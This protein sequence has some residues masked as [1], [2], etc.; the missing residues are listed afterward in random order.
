MPSSIVRKAVVPVAGFGTS[1]LPETKTMPK[2]MLPIVDIP[3]IHFVIEEITKSGI[4]EILLISGHAKRAVEDHFDSS[5]E[6]ED[7]L[8]QS[9]KTALLKEIR[10]ISKVNFHYIRQKQQHGLGDAILCAKD[11]IDGE[12]FIVAHPD[13]IILNDE[14]TGLS[15]LLHQ[16]ETTQSTILGC[17][18]VGA[19]D[20]SKYGIVSGERDETHSDLIRV[21]DITEKPVAE[22]A[23]SHQ[24]VFGRYI[25]TPDVFDYLELTPNGLNGQIQ[26]TD[27][28]RAM[29]HNEP[30]YAYNMKGHFYNVGDKMGYLIA[31]VDY[32]LRRKDLKDD[33]AAYLKDFVSKM[34]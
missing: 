32:G 21:H 10:D 34:E 11:F 5:P 15:Q 12:P 25:I 14:E 9:G 3:A 1:F 33:F 8:F 16:F 24:A 6:L 19:G 23:P 18:K 7:Q 26:L 17:C 4:E 27:A 31:I 13:D 20:V 30:M 22:N 29:S 28:L 2:A